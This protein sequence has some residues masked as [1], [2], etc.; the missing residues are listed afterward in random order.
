M[1]ALS[2]NNRLINTDQTRYNGVPHYMQVTLREVCADC[3][4]IILTNTQIL[5]INLSITDITN[6]HSKNK[7]YCGWLKY[8]KTAG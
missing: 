3:N 6:I 4:I 2:W 1:D 7:G 5:N 8:R